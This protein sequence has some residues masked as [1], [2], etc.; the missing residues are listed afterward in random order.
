MK[1]SLYILIAIIVIVLVVCLGIFLITKESPISFFKAKLHIGV[2]NKVLNEDNC[3]ELLEKYTDKIDKES[4]EAYYLMYST[5]KYMFSNLLAED[6]YSSLYGKTIN[7]LIK[8]AK[9]ETSIDDIKA[10]LKELEN[11]NF[12]EQAS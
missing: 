10:S 8:E 7:E 11:L 1:K 2:E 5:M 9:D 4:D 12:D 3:E 6:P